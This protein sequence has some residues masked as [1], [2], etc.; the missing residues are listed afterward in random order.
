MVYDFVKSVFTNKSKVLLVRH[1]P[2]RWKA[3]T[4]AYRQTLIENKLGTVMTS[5]EFEAASDILAK[6]GI[7]LE[8]ETL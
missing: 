3:K 1:S 2:G 6:K 5:A 7:S 8:I 4:A